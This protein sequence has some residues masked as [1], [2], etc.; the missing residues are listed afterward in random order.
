MVQYCISA[1]TCHFFLNQLN[2]E[3]T[4]KNWYHFSH[5]IVKGREQS[6]DPRLTAR[7]LHVPLISGIRLGA[8]SGSPC[9]VP[10]WHCWCVPCE[11][12]VPGPVSLLRSSHLSSCLGSC[13]FSVLSM[14]LF[15]VQDPH[16]ALCLGIE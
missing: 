3:I 11:A 5:L 9:S 16:S 1:L 14:D 10:R 6:S 4:F 12:S 2:F 7:T 8:C 13:D 15:C